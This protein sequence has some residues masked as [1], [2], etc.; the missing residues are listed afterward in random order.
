[1]FAKFHVFREKVTELTRIS[2][3]TPDRYPM[4]R[5]YFGLRNNRGK[6]RREEQANKV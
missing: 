2:K 1:M 6:A 5:R 4:K 3:I